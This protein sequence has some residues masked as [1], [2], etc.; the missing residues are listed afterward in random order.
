[1]PR[2]DPVSEPPDLN[3]QALELEESRLRERLAKIAAFKQLARELN[4][5]IPG[6]SAGP[7]EAP[8]NPQGTLY[9]EP[10]TPVSANTF[11]WSEAPYIFD[12]TFAGLVR[13]YRAH[14]RS[15]YHQLKH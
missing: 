3:L 6:A 13:A 5:P 11:P 8:S 15:P 1:M 4:I 2:P 14:E 9:P 7:S 10:E 12:H